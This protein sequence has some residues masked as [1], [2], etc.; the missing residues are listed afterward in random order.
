VESKGYES[1]EI[2][3]PAEKDIVV[4]VALDRSRAAG[5]GPAVAPPRVAKDDP[6][7]PKPPETAAPPPPPPPKTTKPEEPNARDR[8]RNLDKSNPWEQ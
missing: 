4:T 3:V 8:I 7:G 2:D 5:G 6:K 1:R